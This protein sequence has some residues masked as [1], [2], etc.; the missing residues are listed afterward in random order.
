[1]AQ[2]EAGSGLSS[3]FTDLMTSLAV[4]FILLLCASLNNAHQESETTRNSILLEMRKSLSDFASGGI[5]VESDPKDPLGL[6][7]LVPEDLLA[8]PI[9]KAEISS[10]GEVFLGTF[11]PK[12]SRIICSSRFAKEIVS[13]VVEGHTDSSGTTEHNVDL[14]QKRSMSVVRASLRVLGDDA[15]SAQK[16]SF[17]RLLSASGRGSAD[18]VTGP[19]GGENAP[20]SRRVVFKIRVRSFEQRQII[21]ALGE[22]GV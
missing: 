22:R 17:L 6:L 4:I 7:V 1:M 3:S 18:L 20:L 8:F 16:A 9:D 13:V 21:E 19:T 15:L 14:S 11:I 12:L 2:R 10:K 5:V